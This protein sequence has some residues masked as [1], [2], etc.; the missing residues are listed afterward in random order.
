MVLVQTGVLQG[1]IKHSSL[2][3]YFHLSTAPLTQVNGKIAV[4]DKTGGGNAALFLCS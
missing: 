1:F 2:W 4:T 3:G